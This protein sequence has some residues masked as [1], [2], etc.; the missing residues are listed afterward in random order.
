MGVISSS[1]SRVPVLPRAINVKMQAFAQVLLV[2]SLG[3]FV[4]AQD[5]YWPHVLTTFGP[6]PG[7][8]S[9]YDPQPRTLTELTDDGWVQIS[10]C[11]DNNPNFPGD[12]FVRSVDDKDMVILLD[13][14]GFIAGLQSVVMKENALDEVYDF[15]NNPY[16]VLGDWNGEEAYFITAYFVDTAIICNGGRTEEEFLNEGTGNRLSFQSGPTNMDL[17]EIP[18]TKDEMLSSQD[19]FYEHLCSTNMGIHFFP[20]IPAAGDDYDCND[21]IPFQALYSPV[22]GALNAFVF[23]HFADQPSNRY[24]HPTSPGITFVAD[25]APKCLNDRADQGYISTMHVWL[26]DYLINC[27]I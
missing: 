12:R 13:G 21:I 18:M 23:S 6:I 5:T 8:G 25:E 1:S 15:T 20:F 27:N 19:V 9:A 11:A 26:G 10:S 4:S 14:N 3:A 22:D 16:Y 17:Q 7:L 2:L 24:E